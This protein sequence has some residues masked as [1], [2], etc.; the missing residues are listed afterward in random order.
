MAVPEIDVAVL[1]R[2]RAAGAPL[3]D[4]REPQE[5]EEFHA[6]GALLIPLGQIPERIDDLPTGATV[7]VICKTG[8]RSAQ[9]VEHLLANGID[10][11]NVAGG[12][13]AWRAAGNAVVTGPAPG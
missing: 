1:A 8:G 12:S 3:V 10:A 2:L 9:A 7:Y 11:V 5:Y 6:P 13:L 4:V